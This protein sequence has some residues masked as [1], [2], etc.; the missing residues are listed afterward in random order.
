VSTTTAALLGALVGAITGLVSATI[1]NFVALRNERTRQEE[2]R[3][4]AYVQALREH[5][6]IAFTEL[7]TVQH[8]INWITWFAK[9][10]PGVLDD[11][12]IASYDDEVHRAFPKLLG[13]IATVAGL[14]LRVYQELRPIM[15]RLYDLDARTA[16]ALRQIEG[17]QDAA[18]QSLRNC[19]AEARE[20][21]K[22]LPPDLARIMEI[23]QS[24]PRP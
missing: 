13:T 20:L 3:R 24:Q 17:D 7:F 5:T 9:Q 1:T 4:A 6:A 14:N 19:W 16:V 10:D 15:D 23:A 21:E 18:V 12:K 11:K 22:T 8:A 2:A